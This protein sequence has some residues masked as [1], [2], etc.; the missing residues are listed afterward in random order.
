MLLRFQVLMDFLLD[1]IRLE[2]V[3]TEI[4]AEIMELFQDQQHQQVFSTIIIN[5]IRIM[6]RPWILRLRKNNSKKNLTMLRI[7]ES[8][9]ILIQQTGIYTREN[10]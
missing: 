3:Q 6:N 9:V 5:K 7:L 4:N 8:K 1:L 2:V 10:G